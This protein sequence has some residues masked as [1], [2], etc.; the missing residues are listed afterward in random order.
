M[1]DEV[2]FGIQVATVVEFGCCCKGIG[3]GQDRMKE[4]TGE[5]HDVAVV[6]LLLQ[7]F[8]NYI[9]VVIAVKC[10]SFQEDVL[11]KK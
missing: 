8:D 5:F 4:Y 2:G 1:E 3:S 6:L 7:L 11:A 9:F 10:H